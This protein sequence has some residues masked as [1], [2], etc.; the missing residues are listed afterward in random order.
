MTRVGDL[1]EGPKPVSHWSRRACSSLTKSHQFGT[2]EA[3]VVRASLGRVIHG[4][5]AAYA[6]SLGSGLSINRGA[7]S[8]S[9]P[10][11]KL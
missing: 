7:S 2:S 10:R 6:I 11:G 1:A 3:T 5:N 9:L 4:T 8:S